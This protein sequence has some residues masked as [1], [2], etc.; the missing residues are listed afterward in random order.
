MRRSYSRA[1]SDGLLSVFAVG[2]LLTVLVAADSRVRDQVSL[3]MGTAQASTEL[4]A[5]GAQARSL[6]AVVVEVA[7]DQSQNH[8]PLMIFVIAATILTLFMVRT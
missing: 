7:K 4:A 3:R 1:L 8:R 5:A 6:I 2:V